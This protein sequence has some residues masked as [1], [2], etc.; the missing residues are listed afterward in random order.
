MKR[1]QAIRINDQL[2]IAH[3]AMRKARIAIAELGK[4]ER[5]E[6]D[7][8]LYDLLLE[9]EWQV[10]LPLYEQFRDLMKLELREEL[11]APSSELTWSDVRLPRD[12]TEAALDDIIMSALTSQWQKVAKLIAVAME[13]CEKLKLAIAPEMIGARLRFLSHAD[14]I[15]GIGDL[16]RWGHSEVRLKDEPISA[17]PAG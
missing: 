15:E 14:R 17:R 2:V 1:E 8:P 10:M 6:L 9:L 7:R 5:L 12:A 16:R 11:P 4:K 3:E 13:G